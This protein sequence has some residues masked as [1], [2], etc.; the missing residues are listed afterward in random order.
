MTGGEDDR[1]HLQNIE[2]GAGCV[3]VW[4]AL[5]ETRREPESDPSEE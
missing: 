4:E 3:R 5:S 2:D 1:E